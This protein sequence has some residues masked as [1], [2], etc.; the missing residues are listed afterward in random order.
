VERA[1][2]TGRRGPPGLPIEDG[3]AA[4]R[5]RLAGLAADPDGPRDPRRG[6]APRVLQRD[7]GTLLSGGGTEL[8]MAAAQSRSMKPGSSWTFRVPGCA[9]RRSSRRRFESGGPGAP[10][11]PGPGCAAKGGS[12]ALV[13][14]CASGGGRT[15]SIDLVHTH[16]DLADYYGRRGGL[17]A[18][19]GTQGASSHQGERDEFR[20]RRLESA[21]LPGPRAPVVRR[22]DAVDRPLFG[23]GFSPSSSRRPRGLPSH[24]TDS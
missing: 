4:P 1:R 18:G 19:R 23:T 12:G 15:E 11:I 14:L 22:R 24:K 21:R 10:P 16:M 13:R 3:A 6:P 7:L 2:S 8:S 17:A 9:T 5:G 20:T